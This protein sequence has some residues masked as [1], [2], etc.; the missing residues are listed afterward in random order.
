ME[1]VRGRKDQRER[2]QKE[3]RGKWKVDIA[4]MGAALKFP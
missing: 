4:P 2:E 3:G 1:G